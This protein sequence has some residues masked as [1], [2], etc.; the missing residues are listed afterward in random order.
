MD[1]KRIKSTSVLQ[2]DSSDCGVACLLSLIQYYGGSSNLEKIRNLS[3]TNIQGTTLLGLIQASNQLGF[4][5][6]GCEADIQSLIAHCAP[7]I[8]HVVINKTMQHYV[9]CYGFDNE[10]FIIFDPANGIVYYS[11]E[12]LDEIWKSHTCLTLV[13]TDN[14]KKKETVSTTKRKWLIELIN[15]DFPIL[16]ISVVLGLAIAIL[17]VTIALFS[18][19]LIDVILPEKDYKRLYIGIIFVFIL[20]LAR[21]GLYAIRQFFLISQ[22]KNFNNRIIASF[23]SK[24]LRLPKSFFDTRKIGDLVARLN[25]TRRIQNVI[26]TIVGT[27]IVDVL[28]MLVTFGF[29][30]YYSWQ[31]AIVLLCSLPFF[32]YILYKHNK[33]I[34]NAQ[35]DVM[36]S[37]SNSE[38]YFIN[39]MQGID[40]I[41]NLNQQHSFELLN[42]TVYGFFQDKIFHLGKINIKLSSYSQIIS[43][44]LT[45]S[46]IAMGSIFIL[47]GTLLLG[48]LMAIITLVGT[49]APSIVNLS[50]IFIPINEAKV[51]FNRMFDIVDF[52]A[53]IIDGENCPEDIQSINIQYV[54]FRFAGRK[55][56][57]KN[58]SLNL[59]K[60]KMIFLIGESGCGKSTLCKILEKFYV[61][62]SGNIL[63]NGNLDLNKIN[64]EDWRNSVG[65]IPQDVF[66]F[67]GTIIE[68]ICLNPTQERLQMAID[69]CEKYGLEKYFSRMPQG[70]MTLVGESGINL[71]GGEKQIIALARILVKNPAIMILDEPTASMDR[72]TEKLTLEILNSIK[73][74]KIIFFVSHRL[75]ILKRYAATICLIENGII[76]CSGTHEEMLQSENLY[77]SYWMELV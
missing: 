73:T 75:H 74:D 29:L 9:V 52:Q 23:Y 21:I 47:K 25:D 22:S 32:A 40:A 67:N 1:L 34:V 15:E 41:K 76:T 17:G 69:I 33:P 64:T 42:Q 50:L 18:Q 62:E 45:V 37:Y 31:I 77:S 49:I 6:N 28:V 36:T 27:L 16:S 20:L 39:T 46:S 66:I 14:F 58:I 51:A 10:K 70:Y 53:E 68:N 54:S 72:E 26:S 30:F 8:L 48:E 2:Q 43:V 59:T 60:G 71:S 12:E 57:L 61:Q 13:V 35:R 63:I 3:G 7:V 38:S 44:I 56:V 11:K 24:L 4:D 65:V 5:A 55:Q 19:K